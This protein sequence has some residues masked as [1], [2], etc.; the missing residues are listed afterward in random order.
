MYQVVMKF[1]LLRR[2]VNSINI[3]EDED[4]LTEEYYIQRK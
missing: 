2:I 4:D 3:L 1:N